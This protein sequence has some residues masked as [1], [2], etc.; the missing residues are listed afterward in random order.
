MQ[1][2]QGQQVAAPVPAATVPTSPSRAWR[3]SVANGT[4][5]AQEGPSG[6]G[7]DYTTA[8]VEDLIHRFDQAVSHGQSGDCLTQ[9]YPGAG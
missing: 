2:K 9:E 1:A 3:P 6:G 5:A 7:A 4:V 8:P